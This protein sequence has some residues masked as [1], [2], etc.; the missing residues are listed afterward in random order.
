MKLQPNIGSDRSWVWKVAADY[1]E[2]P[3]TS[4][5][6]AIRFANSDSKYSSVNFIPGGLNFVPDAGQFKSAFENAQETNIK[7][8][9]QSEETKKVVEEEKGEP[10]KAAEAEE[11]EEEEKE[12]EAEKKEEVA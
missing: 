11:K 1:A 3:P 7:L 2:S 6:L 9:G 5:T 8:A 10:E 12:A 4:E